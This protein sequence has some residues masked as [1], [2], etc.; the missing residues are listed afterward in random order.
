MLILK[1]SKVK[2]AYEKINMSTYLEWSQ[3]SQTYLK[4][5]FCPEHKN[6]PKFVSKIML[7]LKSSKVKIAYEK[8]NMSNI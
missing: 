7:I 8:I 1:S 3:I 2:I 5:L 4:I 6:T